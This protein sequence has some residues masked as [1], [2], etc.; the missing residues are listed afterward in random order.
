[1]KYHFL[2]KKKTEDIYSQGINIYAFNLLEAILLF[3]KDF[4]DTILLA[5]FTPEL[6]K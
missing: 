5:I 4:G 2:Y 1:M 6:K 3:E